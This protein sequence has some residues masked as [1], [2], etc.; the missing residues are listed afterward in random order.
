[1]I[2]P[3]LLSS[4]LTPLEAGVNPRIHRYTRDGW[5]PA[6]GGNDKHS[7]LVILGLD[8]RIHRGT[9]L[10]CKMQTPP[11]SEKSERAVVL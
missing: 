9:F 1:M 10:I 2:D 4:G 8:P 5:I 7:L 6:Q 3:L 11:V